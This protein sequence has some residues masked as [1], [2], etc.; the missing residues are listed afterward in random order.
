MLNVFYLR[1]EGPTRN[2]FKTKFDGVE[3]CNACYAAALGY[4]QRRF[5]QLK[6]AH[7]VYERVAA[8][9]GNTCHL[10]EGAKMM[11]TR[12][13][14]QEFIGEAG[15]TQ[16]HR[17]IRRKV[18]NLVVPLILLPMN[19]TKVDVFHLVN[20]EVKKMVDGEPLSLASFH[21]MWRNISVGWR[22]QRTRPRERRSRSSF[23]CTSDI[24]WKSDA[25]TGCSRG[26][27]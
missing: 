2:K 10:R 15:C 23:F 25:T 13:S 19:T 20:E 24:K 27:L 8:M 18:D 9:H 22:P 26:Q 4:S 3:V 1:T 5:K 7:R 6:V 14:F 21:R 11:A 12:E 17:Q 16:P